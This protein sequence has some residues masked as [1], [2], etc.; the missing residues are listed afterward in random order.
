[1][2]VIGI[3]TCEILE[4]EFARILGDDKE[5]ERISVLEDSHSARLIELLMERQESRLWR[6]PH[7]H[8]FSPEPDEPLEVI[9]RVLALGLHRNRRVLRNALAKAVHELHPRIGALLLGYG[10]CGGALDDIE[11]VADVDVPLFLPMDNGHLVDDCVALCLGGRKR[12]YGEQRQCAGTF[13]LTPGWSQHWRRMLD[14]ASGEVTQPGLQRLLTG[15]ERG[16]LVQSPAL[17]EEILQRRGVEFQQQTALRLET[18]VGTMNLLIDAWQRTKS[19]VRS[20][21]GV[22]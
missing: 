8:A 15:Y 6:L 14:S 5:I 2:A 3:I 10:L 21:A 19:A 11:S 17:D 13:F 20:E 16:L 9:V 12:Y 1:M 22:S 18:Q 4:L 7:P